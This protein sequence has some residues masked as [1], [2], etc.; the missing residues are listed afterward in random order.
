MK[1]LSASL[2]SVHIGTGTDMSKQPYDSV[3]VELD[4]F[5]GDKHRGFSRI[6]Y[7]GDTE[8]AGTVRRNN[9]QWSGMSGEELQAQYPAGGLSRES[10]ISGDQCRI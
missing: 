5:V 8:P 3:V 4:G 1:N 9:R 7:Q 10:F 2:V 6:C